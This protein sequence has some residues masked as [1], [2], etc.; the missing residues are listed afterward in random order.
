MRVWQD[1]RLEMDLLKLDGQLRDTPH[2]TVY[3]IAMIQWEHA[4]RFYAE[5]TPWK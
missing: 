3:L 5:A 4:F 1:V 2:E